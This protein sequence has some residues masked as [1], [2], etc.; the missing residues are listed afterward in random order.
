MFENAVKNK[1]NLTR[2]N[3]KSDFHIAFGISKTFTYPVGVLITS[4]LENNKDMKI[5]FHIFVDDKIEDKEL[6][7]FK[8]LVEFYDTDIIIYE[9]D[10]SEFLNL[11]DREFTIAAYYR[12]AIPYQLKDITDKYLYIDADMIL[13][14]NGGGKE[15]C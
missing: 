5:N 15:L 14:K 3:K 2:D 6:N 11:D 13:I 1:I 4:I 9:I 10:N 12:F 8:E 7:R